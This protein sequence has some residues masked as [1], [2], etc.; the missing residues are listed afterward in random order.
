MAALAT[1]AVAA[2]ETSTDATED[3]YESSADRAA[4]LEQE[5]LDRI[6]RE[7]REEAARIRK[8]EEERKAAEESRR[9]AAEEAER[10]R[11]EH[12]AWLKMTPE[13]RQGIAIKKMWI[14]PCKEW[15]CQQ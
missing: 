3:E 8:A 6:E 13:Q 9:K 14:S 10:K 11:K 2:H 7:K 5:R 4:R 15:M 1:M 12:E